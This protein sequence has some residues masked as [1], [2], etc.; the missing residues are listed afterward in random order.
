ME[1]NLDAVALRLRIPPS[2]KALCAGW[3]DALQASGAGAARCLERAFVLRAGEDAELTQEMI[4]ELVDFA[5]RISGDDDLLAFF[6][7][8]RHRVLHDPTLVLSWEE[9]WPAL[10]DR[11][12]PEAGLLNALVML[13][14]VPE[15]RRTYRRLGLPP[16]IVR[17]TVGDLR[18]WM[19]TDL[20]ALRFHRHGITPWIARWLCKHWQGKVLR[21]GRLQFSRCAFDGGLHAYRSRAS[22][23]IV[24]L[25]APGIRYRPDGDILGPC[26]AGSPGDWTSRFERTAEDV[27]GNPLLPEGKALPVVRRLPFAEWSEALAP[28]DAMLMF[29]V[30]T[31]APLNFEACGASFRQALDIFPRF[32]PELDFKG[33][34]TRSWLLDPRWSQLLPPS[35]NIVRLQRAMH[36]FPGLQGDNRQVVQ[37][38]FG[39]DAADSHDVPWRTTL[40]QA[41]GR[42]LEEGGHF[43]G[44]FGFLLKEDFRWEE[45]GER[46]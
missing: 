19:E 14:A 25:S 28:G 43:H 44:G 20:Y 33:F 36:L 18:L 41:A 27:L 17:D 15:M 42:Y 3:D 5:E 9:P 31:G 35:S 24:A 22:G 45:R 21:L 23:D 29:H 12:G 16:A 7:Y 38:V 34:W 6:A 46:G 1:R 2:G 11:L 10:D 37:R 32:F 8:C 4:R 26:C 13:S 30:P 39:W 40:Q